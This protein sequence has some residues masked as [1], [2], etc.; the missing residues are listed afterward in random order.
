MIILSKRWTPQNWT[1]ENSLVL[2]NQ[3]KIELVQLCYTFQMNC[4]LLFKRFGSIAEC[5]LGLLGVVLISVIA[6]LFVSWIGFDGASIYVGGG[7]LLYGWA[8]V[9]WQC[10]KTIA[11]EM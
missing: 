8:A 11:N 9:L 6:A 4:E 10:A 3:R 1:V 2:I 7:I 5:T